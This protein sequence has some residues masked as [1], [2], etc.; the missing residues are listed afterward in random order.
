[1]SV[2]AFV[3]ARLYSKSIPRKNIKPFCR[4]PLIFWVLN[5][6][7][8]TVSI[9]K[10]IVATDGDV[11]RDIV[12]SFS[13]SKVEI[14]DRDPNNAQDDSSTESVMLEYINFSDLLDSDVFMLVQITSPFT[15]E[16]H[17]NQGLSLLKDYNSVLSCCVSK[18]FLWSRDGKALNYDIY[19]RPRRQEYKGDLIE[20]GAFYISSVRE[21]RKTKNRISG[22]IGI[23]EMPE[24]TCIEID[25]LDDWRLAEV[26][27]TKYC[28]TKELDLSKIKIFLSDVDGVLTDGGMYYSRDGDK[29]KKFCTH[30]GMGLKIIQEKGV[31]V[32]IITS[33]DTDINRKRV[34]KLSLD[35]GF[36]GVQDKLAVVKELCDKENISFNEL[37]YIGDDINCFNLLC[38]AGISACP[39][40]AV[41]SIKDIPGIIHLSKNGGEGV[42]REFIEMFF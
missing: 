6:L 14:Y 42:V 28:I 3:P 13:F 26:L 22:K 12:N 24:Y 7:Q 35:F 31:K 15:R 40:N 20:N 36:H 41:D 27:F 17:F 16:I 32:G 37:A 21:I 25:E 33:E 1:M 8:N 18:R 5:E 38:N 9:D 39:N 10:I 23:Y 2:I 34:E 29:M 11:I 4:K 30:D 19:D